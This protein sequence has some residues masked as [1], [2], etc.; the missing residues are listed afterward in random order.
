MSTAS[1]HGPSPRIRGRRSVWWQC[2]RT[3]PRR[4]AAWASCS[5]RSWRRPVDLSA[6]QRLTG[7]F[8][9]IDTK[10]PAAGDVPQKAAPSTSAAPRITI[11]EFKRLDLRVAEVV[12]AEP[13]P[14]SKK[15]LKLTV[16]L[17]DETR[18]LVAGIAEHYRPEAVVGRK[19]VVVANL[20][21]ATLMGVTSNGMVLAGSAGETLALLSLERD[22][23]SGAKVR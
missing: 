15:L 11:D 12:A 20:E 22:L 16:R 7:L 18:T 1:S 13:V 14:K 5:C 6:V 23:P 10:A 8:P 4:C 3:S 9:R 17:G 2:W 21:P 19:V